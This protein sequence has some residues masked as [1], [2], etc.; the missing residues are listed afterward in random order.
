V[1]NAILSSAIVHTIARSKLS[2]LKAKLSLLSEMVLGRLIIIV[3]AAIVMTFRGL[4]LRYK[5]RGKAFV[6]HYMHHYIITDSMFKCF[7][8]ILFTDKISVTNV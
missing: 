6:F 1:R 3:T 8:L 5:G 7:Y 4:S 2:R